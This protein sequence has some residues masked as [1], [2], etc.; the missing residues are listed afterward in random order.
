MNR[1]YSL[2]GALYALAAPF[3]ALAWRGAFGGGRCAVDAVCAESPVWLAGAAWCLAAAYLLFRHSGKPLAAAA[4]ASAAGL[5]AA[6]TACGWAGGFGV[7]A[8]LC[9]AG[10]Q[11]GGH[12]GLVAQPEKKARLAF[13][14]PAGAGAGRGR[15]CGDCGGR[16]ILSGR[17]AV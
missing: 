5:H 1:L 10:P 15:F 3:C 2:T 14:G 8:V 16:G 7:Q 9:P 17:C 13:S 12:S 11:R 4:F 6:A